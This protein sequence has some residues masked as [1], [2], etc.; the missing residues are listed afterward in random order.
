[1]ENNT[2]F[3]FAHIIWQKQPASA[4]LN[5][6]EAMATAGTIRK[7]AEIKAVDIRALSVLPDH[8]HM[9]I[10]LQPIHS[11]QQMVTHLI[12]ESEN[13][14]QTI[15]TGGEI[16]QWIPG[17][18]AFSISPNTV[19]KAIDYIGHQAAYHQQ[20]TMEAELEKLLS[21]VAADNS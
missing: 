7:A 6:A 2:I 16:F 12:A 8:V 11:L 17:Y 1:M 20:V 10:C 19:K 21:M 9:L 14:L 18:Y 13:F 15:R 3:L 4:S 5:Q